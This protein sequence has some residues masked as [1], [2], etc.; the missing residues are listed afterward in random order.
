MSNVSPMNTDE[1]RGFLNFPGGHMNP[2][3]PR[4][5]IWSIMWTRIEKLV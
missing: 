2:N 5:N 1:E 4:Q 3:P